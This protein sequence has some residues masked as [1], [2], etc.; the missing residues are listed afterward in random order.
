M[1]IKFILKNLPTISIFIIFYL[2]SYFISLYIGFNRHWSVNFDQELIL[3]YNA[4]LF[5]NGLSLEYLDHPGYFTILFLS[6]FVKFLSFFDLIEIYKLSLLDGKNFNESLQNIA[7][8]TRIFSS[9][10]V[11]FFCFA[12]YLLFYSFTKN[13]I[14]SLFL[15]ILIICSQGTIFHFSQLRT[16]L[17]AMFFLVLSILSLKTFFEKRF[18]NNI[19]Y[20]IGFFI[21]LFCSLLNKMQIFFFIPLILL[22]I[23]F[24]ENKIHNFELVNFKFLENKYI[25]LIILF[26]YI[27][28]LYISNHTLHPFPLFSFIV[29]LTNLFLINLFFYFTY[30]NQSVNLKNNLVVINLL[31]IVVFFVLKNI[32]IIH[33]ST[34]ELIFVN[35][36]RIMDLVQF[37]PDASGTNEISR[38][39]FDLI[40]KFTENIFYIIKN[41]FFTIN[42]YSFLILINIFLIIFFKKNLNNKQILFN[43]CCLIVS[44]FILM[45]N[46]LRSNGSILIHYYIF[47]DIFLI[48]PLC[49]FSKFLKKKYYL[50]I[51]LLVLLVNFNTNMNNIKEYK[52]NL[53]KNLNLCNG[54]FYLNWASKIDRTYFDD[55]CKKIN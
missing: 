2:I 25:P 12:T 24:C 37:I 39:F 29:V 16:E 19:I 52:S 14:Y 23:Y 3:I 10:C 34:N 32:L 20:I 49:N 17:I 30:K 28:Y 31:L 47:S 54:N 7:F 1:I 15:S 53:S 8:F 26:I 18:K 11:S 43:L 6:L 13:K 33:P 44:I 51:L 35:L 22:I 46:S 4:L 38:L 21:F 40:S 41:H 9:L 27:Y 42:F 5:N 50:I 36:T 55:F 48:L 45:I